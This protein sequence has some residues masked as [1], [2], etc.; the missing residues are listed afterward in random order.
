[1]ISS[2]MGAQSSNRQHKGT[3]VYH[4]SMDPVALPIS[5][6]PKRQQDKSL[7]NAKETISIMWNIPTK[8]QLNSTR[9]D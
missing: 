4:P 7:S 9:I 1:M 2:V 3:V 6:E 8:T 5:F